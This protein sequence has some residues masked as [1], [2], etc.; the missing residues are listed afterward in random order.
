[1]GNDNRETLERMIDAMF[2]GDWEAVGETIADDAV[3][4][5]P[6]SGER[7]VGRQ[8]CLNVYRNY[9]GGS[10]R[11]ELQRIT[12]GPEVFTVEAR[13][14]YPGERVYMT[15]I[16]EFREGKIARQTDYFASAFEAPAW[17]AEWVQRV[18]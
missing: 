8:A 17:R 3:V 2:Q 18:G 9:P 12:G 6:Q 13:G 10:P 14:E 15:S 4:E 5:Y 7:L 1:M 16:V 11:Y